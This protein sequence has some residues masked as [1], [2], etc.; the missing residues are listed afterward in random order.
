M[1]GCR[2]LPDAGKRAEDER[3][4]KQEI[5]T[6]VSPVFGSRFVRE[7][8]QDLVRKALEPIWVSRHSIARD[9]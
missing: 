1:S 3:S 4:W 8:D 9:L 2:P 7:I 5:K 6:Y